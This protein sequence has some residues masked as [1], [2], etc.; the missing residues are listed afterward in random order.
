ME[1]LWALQ[2]SLAKAQAQQRT[3]CSIATCPCVRTSLKCHLT[4]TLV[5]SPMVMEPRS[6]AAQ[7]Q[8]AQ[9]SLKQGT[10]GRL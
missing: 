8:R 9:G 1:H 4:C 10:H 6:A 7:E 5:L 3:S 2:V